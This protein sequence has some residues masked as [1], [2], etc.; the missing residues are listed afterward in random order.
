MV[1]TIES[2]LLEELDK[3][4]GEFRQKDL[5][6]A[7]AFNATH[8]D[9]VRAGQT[10]SFEKTTVKNKEGQDEEK[11]RQTA[12]A[13]ADVD[14]TKLDNLLSAI[15]QARASG[16]AGGT[17]KTGLDSPEL[18]ATVKSD[19]GRRSETVKFAR[20]GGDAY[21]ERTGESGAARIDTSTLDNI[22]KAIDELQKPPTSGEQKPADKDG[23]A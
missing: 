9:V 16:F 3:D 5:F 19:E 17:A 20:S 10:L 13:A 7:R 2:S 1:V 23:G 8:L 18:T 14:Q 4:A 21:A 15:T 12:P 6:D 22:V 11:W